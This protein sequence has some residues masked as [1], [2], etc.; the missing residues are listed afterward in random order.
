VVDGFV[1]ARGADGSR[2][3]TDVRSA[4]GRPALWRAPLIGSR[5]RGS[6]SRR[7]TPPTG[8]VLARSAA[9]S[10]AAAAA[11]SGE[12]HA[13]ASAAWRFERAATSADAFWATQTVARSKN[14]TLSARVEAIED[15]GELADG[16][17]QRQ[18]R[19]RAAFFSCNGRKPTI[20]F[21]Q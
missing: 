13:C 12:R 14:G 19:L 4:E 10:S 7:V 11:E 2:R 8:G 20:Q 18:K 3:T 17:Q 16:R 1:G 15:V 21:K 6:V 5:R 9:L